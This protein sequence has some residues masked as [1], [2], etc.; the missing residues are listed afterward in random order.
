[1]QNGIS[2]PRAAELAN[3][4]DGPFAATEDMVLAEIDDLNRA[5]QKERS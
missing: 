3:Q 1:M 4:L 5:E 2:N